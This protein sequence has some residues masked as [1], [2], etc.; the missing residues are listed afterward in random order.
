[1]RLI[2]AALCAVCVVAPA[3][4]EIVVKTAVLK[5]ERERP[6][7]ISRLDLPPEGE[8]FAGA[9]LAIDDN[10]TTGRFMGQSYALFEV[11][12]TPDKALEAFDA[13]R[14]DGVAIVATIA[15]APDLLAIADHASGTDALILNA[16][17]PDDAL[18]GVECRA[19]V[20]HV[21]PSRA[22]MADGLAPYLGW[23]RGTDWALVYGSHPQDQAK[24][25]AFR[26]AARKFGARIVEERLFEDTGGAR[27]SD[28][29]HVQVQRQIPTFMQRM[30]E[31]HVVIAADESQ[32]FGVYLPYRGWEPRP[33]AGDAGLRALNWHPAHES[34]GATQMQR[35]FERAA[36]RAMTDLDYNAWVALRAVGEAVTR[37]ETADPTALRDYMRSEAFELGAFK[38]Q[39]L[40]F[41]PW[42]NQLRQ[43]I[44]LAD[45]RNVVSI[46]PQE[47][48]LH[49][50]TRLDTLGQDEPDSA[51]DF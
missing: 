6:L 50:R 32:V 23:K 42:N 28:S 34:Y 26:R 1:M 31:H 18:R 4:A 5:V 9:R 8:G 20:M 41:R 19:N 49:Q 2:V 17:A 12:T 3:A 36:G 10:N 51:C 15:D 25:D 24:A 22:M 48:F 7:P 46:S 29:G 38:G 39:P 43:A 16:S 13:L 35:R 37:A 21:A 33:V 40:S 44:V 47:E 14:A 30:A 45:G 11:T 27:R